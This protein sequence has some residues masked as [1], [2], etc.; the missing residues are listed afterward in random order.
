MYDNNRACFVAV[1]AI[2]LLAGLSGCSAAGR[3]G[4]EAR[5]APSYRGYVLAPDNGT[6]DPARDDPVMLLRDPITERKIRCREDL[7]RWIR[8][9]RTKA[10]DDIHDENCSIASPLLMEPATVGSE[11]IQNVRHV[12]KQGVHAYDIVTR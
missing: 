1:V 8:H 10:Q 2:A 11:E 3:Y 9:Y 7:E 4:S 12:L 6:Q 5:Y